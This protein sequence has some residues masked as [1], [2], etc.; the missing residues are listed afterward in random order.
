MIANCIDD[1]NK[2]KL[3]KS[4]ETNEFIFICTTSGYDITIVRMKEEDDF[5]IVN[6]DSY[7]SS[8]NYYI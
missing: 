7:Y 3:F 6:K 5:K 2:F 1:Y 8:P 4:K